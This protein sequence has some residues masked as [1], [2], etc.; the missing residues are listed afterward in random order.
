MTINKILKH[1]FPNSVLPEMI[2]A[3]CYKGIAYCDIAGHLSKPFG[4][5]IG[6]GQGDPASSCRFNLIHHMYVMFIIILQKNLINETIPSLPES[7]DIVPTISFA[8]DT[9]IPVQFFKE[10]EVDTFLYILSLGKLMTGLSINPS[11]TQ[12]LT[13]YCDANNLPTEH[14]KFLKKLGQTTNSAIHLGLI[15]EKSWRDSAKA[16]WDKTLVSLKFSAG[17]E[18]PIHRKQLVQSFNQKNQD[19]WQSL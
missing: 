5:E 14:K 10:S 12:I 2:H 4:L 17:S 3:L 1:I 6:A 11:K 7:N 15:V 9:T 8:D 13:L 19:V 18:N 16:S